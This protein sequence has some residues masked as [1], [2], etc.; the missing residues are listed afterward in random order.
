MKTFE[1]F[2]Y[3]LFT[4]EALDL[5]NFFTGASSEKGVVTDI[6]TAKKEGI[7]AFVDFFK[8][9]LSEDRTMKFFDILSKIKLKLIRTLKSR[10]I[11]AKNKEIML[12]ADQNIFGMMTVI[13]LSRN[14]DTKDV[15]SHP[16]G[17]IPWLLATSDGTLR[18]T[19]KAVLSNN[20]EK[21]WMQ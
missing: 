20:I 19:N 1:L 17:R 18:K 5:C 15:L 4:I 7:Q 6:L 13:S 8:K 14:L 9:R 3:N 12:K 11:V 16:L 21:Q 10:K 2:I